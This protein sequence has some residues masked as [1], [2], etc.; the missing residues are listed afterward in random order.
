MRKILSIIFFSLI[1]FNFSFAKN[2]DVGMHNLDV[3]SKFYLVNWNET[4]FA[5]EM[6]KEFQSCYGIVDN[7]IYEIV[8]K[9]NSGVSFDKIQILKPLISKYQKVMASDK[10]FERQTKGL[11]KMFKSTLNKNK[12]GT[13]FGYYNTAENIEEYELLKE[14]DIDIDEIKKMSRSELKQL[15][16]E[17]KDEITSGK[18]YYMLMDGMFINFDKFIIDKNSNNTPYLIFN[19]DITYIIGSSKVKIGNVGYYLSEFSKKLFVL[20]GYCIVK[21]SNFFPTFDKII[22]KSFNQNSL[23]KSVSTSN[24]ANFI[25]QLKQLNNLYKSGVL[26]KEE[27]EKAKKELLN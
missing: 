27:F 17:I 7:K 23:S 18:N 10:N 14:Y 4:D 2:L 21:C 13:I 9:L 1:M 8:E 25:K 26:T 12:S 20:D 3:P 19:G 5:D 15:T 16:S 24:D 22:E 11:I 6:C